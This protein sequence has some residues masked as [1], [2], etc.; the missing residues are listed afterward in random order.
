MTTN[1]DPRIAQLR[2]LE[3]KNAALEELMGERTDSID[4]LGAIQ[5]I[6]DS[7]GDDL[8]DFINSSLYKELLHFSQSN[9]ERTHSMITEWVE[10]DNAISDL[11]DEITDPG[12]I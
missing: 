2:A 3:S 1:D 8:K 11:D 5:I 4:F 7:S 10:R 9:P 12:L 6:A